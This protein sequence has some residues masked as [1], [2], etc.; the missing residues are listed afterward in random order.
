MEPGVETRAE[1][2][3][4]LREPD[5]TAGDNG[6][7]PP[8]PEPETDL[9]PPLEDVPP[10][11]AEPEGRRYPSTIGGMFYLAVLGVAAIG[12]G[13]VTQG[14]WRLGV[15][16]IA[17][18]LVLAAVVRLVIPAQQAGMLAVRR[19]A[20]DVVILAA[21]GVALWFLSV[22]IPNVALL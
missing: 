2:D 7:D 9:D 10:E 12:L 1:V 20:L 16:W 8:E 5:A 4:E 22:S 21:M 13:I 11:S 18:A 6:G 3:V 17:A 19:R 14:S 15:K